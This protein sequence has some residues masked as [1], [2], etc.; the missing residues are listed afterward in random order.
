MIAH[1]IHVLSN[2]VLIFFIMNYQDEGSLLK[3]IGCDQ[4]VVLVS[5]NQ[6]A[7]SYGCLTFIIKWMFATHGVFFKWDMENEN[8]MALGPA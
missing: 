7:H 3:N 1:M 5:L 6:H 8:M 2:I 4:M